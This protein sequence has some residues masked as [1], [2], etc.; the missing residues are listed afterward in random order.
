[1]VAKPTAPSG[2]F[3]RPALASSDCQH[4]GLRGVDDGG[5]FAYAVH[6]QVGDG[7]GPALIFVGQEFPVAGA[8]REILHLG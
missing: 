2:S 3:D 7:G 6:S 1:M 4:S 8:R 5:K